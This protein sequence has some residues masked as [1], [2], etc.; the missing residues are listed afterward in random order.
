MPRP[1]SDVRAYFLEWLERDGYPLW[2]FWENVRSWW[3]IRQLPN[4]RLLHFAD[5]KRDMPGQIR[6]IAEFL[7]VPIH[8]ESWE[9]IL[10]HCSFDYMKQNATKSA[11]LG[12]AFWDG[13]AQV[14]VNR[15]INGRW[16]DVLT[17]GDVAAYD[18]R[19]RAELGDACA[20]WLASG[21]R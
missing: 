7:E 2:P 16:T 15:G 18:T 17:P 10:L 20:S 5:L 13:G 21:A 1:G 14:F 12:G 19:A 3:E 4:V 9:R 11:P 6:A 8:D